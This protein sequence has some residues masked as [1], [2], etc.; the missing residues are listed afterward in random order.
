[1]TVLEASAVQVLS[2]ADIAASESFMK[3][4]GDLPMKKYEKT[5]HVPCKTPMFFH[6]GGRSEQP[7]AGSPLSSPLK[8]QVSIG[9]QPDDSRGGWTGRKHRTPATSDSGAA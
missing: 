5:L 3:T 4:M 9:Q 1:M 6:Q 7:A 8:R 2:I